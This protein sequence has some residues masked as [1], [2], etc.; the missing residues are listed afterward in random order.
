MANKKFSQK[1]SNGMKRDAVL[2]MVKKRRSSLTKHDNRSS[3]YFSMD[4]VLEVLRT[5]SEEGPDASKSIKIQNKQKIV[6]KIRKENKNTMVA[7]AGI[8]DILGFN[9]SMQKSKEEDRKIK[10]V[11]ANLKVY[12]DN[13]LTL[14]EIVQHRL[15]D[16]TVPKQLLHKKND[17]DPEFALTMLP[18]GLE[19]LHEI[20]EALGRIEN[21]TFGICEIT[22]ES[23]SKERLMVFPFTRYSVAGKKEHEQQL[24]IK[25]K[26]Q[27]SGAFA[28]DIDSGFGLYDDEISEE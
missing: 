21:N 14:R 26:A 27:P 7:A 16:E 4:D 19:A 28:E 25:E 3:N 8:A 24:A 20:D 17:F 22:G 9:P 10:D 23:I 15:N 11:A 5:R 2:E 1:K 13:L 18:S 12:Y 6:E